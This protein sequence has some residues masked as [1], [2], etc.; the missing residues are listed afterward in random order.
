MIEIGLYMLLFSFFANFLRSLDPLVIA[1]YNR[2]ILLLLK[3]VHIQNQLIQNTIIL[4]R[5]TPYEYL[6]SKNIFPENE[7]PVLNVLK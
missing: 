3:F 5:R 2:I 7:T 6:Q 4:S 1:D